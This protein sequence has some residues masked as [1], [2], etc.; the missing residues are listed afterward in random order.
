M[1]LW[2]LR[3]PGSRRIFLGAGGWDGAGRLSFQFGE[4]SD[5][6]KTFSFQFAGLSD[7][8]GDLCFQ[9]WGLSDD[10]ESDKPQN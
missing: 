7:T 2:I 5:A 9:I 6:R 8:Y 3:L 4:L 1:C 10:F